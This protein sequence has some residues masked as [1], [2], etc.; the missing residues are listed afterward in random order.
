MERSEHV[1]EWMRITDRKRQAEKEAV[2]AQLAPKLSQRGRENEGRP[3]GGINAASR[4]LGIDRTEAQRAVKIDAI[5]PE[6]KAASETS[7][8]VAQLAGAEDLAVVEI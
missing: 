1:A 2:P 3:E 8:D 4:E 6:A 7:Q 5:A